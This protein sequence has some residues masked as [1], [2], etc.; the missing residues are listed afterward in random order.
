MLGSLKE[1]MP[2][3]KLEWFF[4][5]PSSQSCSLVNLTA[6]RN[7]FPSTPPLSLFRDQSVVCCSKPPLVSH[8]ILVE[9]DGPTGFDIWPQ[10]SSGV[11][12]GGSYPDTPCGP[13]YVRYGTQGPPT[14]GIDTTVEPH[15]SLEYL[16]SSSESL[17]WIIQPSSPCLGLSWVLIAAREAGS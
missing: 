6:C 15:S 16:L 7:S 3:S 13:D 9:P 2:L 11:V 10:P 1:T 14:G 12:L 17:P 8:G 5:W 4:P